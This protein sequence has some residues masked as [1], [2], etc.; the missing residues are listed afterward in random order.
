MTQEK[1]DHHCAACHKVDS[2]LKSCNA[3]K[4]VKYCGVDQNIRRSTG[5]RLWNCLTFDK[6]LFAMPPH[7][8]DCV[9]CC[10]HFSLIDE[11]VHQSCCGKIICF[12]CVHSM[13]RNVCPFGICNLPA[14]KNAKELYPRTSKRIDQYNDPM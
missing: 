5:I 8:K 6:K 14:H 10:V 3:C 7:R 2:A 13:T 9:M 4:L 1:N 12:G 11:S